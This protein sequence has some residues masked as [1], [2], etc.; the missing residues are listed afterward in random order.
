MSAISSGESVMLCFASESENT[1]T[2]IREV[3]TAA[4]GQTSEANLID[5]IR[6]SPNFIPELSIVAVEAGE[7]LGHILFSPIVIETQPQ[8]VPALAL[9]P[10]AVTPARQREGIG[11]QLV[12]VGLS[13]C[14][15]LG[16]QIVVVLGHSDYYPSF[17]FQKASQFGVQAPF[18]VPDEAF[19]VL[20]LQPGA[21]MGVS[22][23][24]RYPAY[25]DE[26]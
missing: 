11:R 13:K 12:Q 1:T 18:P 25:F 15:E 22:G 3:V 19:M 16:H 26:V 24:V 10:L 4:F 17:G 20:E 21:L 7:V 5:T 2:G 6:H 14:R 23:I 9:A 8:S